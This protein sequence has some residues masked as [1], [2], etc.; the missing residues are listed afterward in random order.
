MSR[1]QVEAVVRG[2]E[3]ALVAAGTEPRR[4]AV[5]IL[6]SAILAESPPEFITIPAYD[7]IVKDSE[8]LKSR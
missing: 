3:A 2:E 4:E 7:V 8:S 5:D 6:L 1:E